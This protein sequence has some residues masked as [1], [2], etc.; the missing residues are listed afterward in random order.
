MNRIST[1][2]EKINHADTE[3]SDAR[4]KQYQEELAVAEEI[5]K[6]RATSKDESFDFMN[7]KLPDALENPLTYAD[8]WGKAINIL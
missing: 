1:L 2:Q 8:N 4:L 5:A 7:G 6:V 3:T